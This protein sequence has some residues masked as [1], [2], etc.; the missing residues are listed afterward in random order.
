MNSSYVFFWIYDGRF[1]LRKEWLEKTK[2]IAFRGQ[3][4]MLIVCK[5]LLINP[6]LNSILSQRVR[7]RPGYMLEI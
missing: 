1:Y 3:K 5:E 2:S 4:M 7:R 6:F